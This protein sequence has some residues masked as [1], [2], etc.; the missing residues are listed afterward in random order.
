VSATQCWVCGEHAGF[1]RLQVRDADTGADAYSLDLCAACR[2]GAL[3]P[4]PSAEVLGRHYA[5]S[6]Y[7]RGASKFAAPLQAI[8]NLSTRARAKSI[9]AAVL[10]APAPLVLDIGCSRGALL[11][12]LAALGARG[13]GLERAALV[14]AGADAGIDIRVGELAAQ[15]FASASFDAVVLWHVLEHLAHPQ[16]VLAE[17]GRILKPGGLLLIAVPNNASWQA[18]FFGRF[19][20]HLDVPRHLHFFGHAGLLGLLRQQ[21]YAVERCGTYDTVQNVF[22]FI[23]SS[24]N[25]LPGSAPNRLYQLMRSEQSVLGILELLLW[26]LP[27]ALLLPFALV[28]SAWCAL[29]A[30]GASSIVFASRV[31]PQR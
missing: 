24:L 14:V 26:A 27:A 16:P 22:G 20:F 2:S 28:E 30:R 6:Y 21:G 25:A 8:V 1:D 5:A 31:G 4:A 23:Q 7:G 18:R 9:R 13:V 10:G 29:H 15:R 17:I 12:E 3:E 19:W 11:A